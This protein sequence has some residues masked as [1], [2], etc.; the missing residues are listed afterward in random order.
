MMTTENNAI[1]TLTDGQTIELPYS[2]IINPGDWFSKR[3]AVLVSYGYSGD[4][5]IVEA[6]CESDAMD[7][8]VESGKAG[9]LVI[10]P[11]DLGDY[12][13][14]S[15]DYR[16][17]F[18]GDGTPY[19]TDWITGLAS[20]ESVL[21]Q[22][23]APRKLTQTFKELMKGYRTL[24]RAAMD[25]EVDPERLQ[26][27]MKAAIEMLKKLEEDSRKVDYT[28]KI[29]PNDTPDNNGRNP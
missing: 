23:K 25:E 24:A 6:G 29:N 12:R 27:E 28:M 11:D 19:D 17:S 21:K 4:W 5:Y 13:D 10:D 2:N 1:A 22:Q 18:A 26:E 7:V 9:Y 20:V 8:L 16:C 14:E 15:G 3:W